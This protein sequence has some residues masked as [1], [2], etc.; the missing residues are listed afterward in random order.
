MQ[1]NKKNFL[2]LLSLAAVI[3]MT[4]FAYFLPANGAYAEGAPSDSH[5]DIIRVTVY[6]QYPAVKFTAPEDGHTQSSS[7]YEFTFDYENSS[8]VNVSLIYDATDESTGDVISKEL[9]LKT[10]EPSELDPVFSYASGTQQYNIDLATC[11]ISI[12]GDKFNIP[13]CIPTRTNGLLMFIPPADND[14]L[15]YNKY[16]L[17]IESHSPIGYDEDF[18][19]FYYVPAYLAQIGSADITQNPVVEV[20]YDEGVAKIEIMPVDSDGNPL[21][22]EPTV[23][24]LNPDETGKYPA[25][26]QSIALPFTESGF[27]TGEYD[28]LVTAYSATVVP[29]EIDPSTGEPGEDTIEYE[30]IGSPFD[31]YKVDYVQPPA[32]DVPNTGRFAKGS[33]NVAKSDYVITAVIVFVVIAIVAFLMVSRKKKDYRRNVRSRK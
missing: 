22:D 33:L 21:F 7:Y 12:D 1:K 24:T 26:S 29:G 8:Y 11:K 5:T 23:I 20:S 32:P 17:H 16:T 27:A 31:L 4:V 3:A 9:P 25:G 6:D 28:V 13:N 30:V 15:V 19:E 2:G 14:K 10:F 18:I